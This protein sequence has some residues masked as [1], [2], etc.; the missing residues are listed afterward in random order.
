M[1]RATLLEHLEQAKA[2]V[3]DD[4]LRIA[5]QKALI[6]HLNRDGP[7]GLDAEKYL[8]FLEGV[9]ALHVTNRNRLERELGTANPE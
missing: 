4:A 1:E 3:A 2:L 7:S 5:R 9:Q 8:H 6:H